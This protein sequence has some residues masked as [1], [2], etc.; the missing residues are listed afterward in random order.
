MSATTL[1]PPKL[2]LDDV[3]D[4]VR[5]EIVDGQLVEMEPMSAQATSISNR[6]FRHVGNYVEA[7][8]IGQAFTEM[9]IK[10]RLKRD[11]NRRPDACFISA[12]EWPL[13]RPIPATNAWPVRPD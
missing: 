3:A 4:P 8:K 10:L 1:P 7:K 5:Y 13:D 2:T 6:L 9:L 11:R 12:D